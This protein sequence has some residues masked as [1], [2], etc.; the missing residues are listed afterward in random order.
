MVETVAVELHAV[1]EEVRERTFR[2]VAHL[3]PRPADDGALPDHEPAVVGSGSRRRLRG[4]VAQPSAGRARA[5]A[6]GP[7]RAVR[8]VRDAPAGAWRPR[9]PARRGAARVHGGGARARAG[10]A[11][12]RRRAARAGDPPRAPAHRD[13]AAGDDARGHHCR[14]RSPAR[15]RCPAPGWRWSRCAEG[16][17]EQGTGPEGFAYDNERPRHTR[18]D[19]PAS[20]SAARRSPT[21]PGALRPRTAAT[22]GASGGR[23]PAGRGASARASRPR[24]RPARPTRRSSTS[25]SSRPR[26]SPAPTTRGCR[27][28]SSGRRRRRAARGRRGGLGVDRRATSPATR[29]SS[30]TR[31]GSIRKCSSA[32]AT[33]CSAGVPVP[34][35]R[36]SPPSSSVT[37]TSPNAGSS[38]PESGSRDEDGAR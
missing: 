18:V 35:T 1:M 38:L 25:P 30:R 24:R 36:V 10:G 26:P 14:R 11:D 12:H 34:R 37:G 4:S 8:R 31:T 22:R 33:G 28:R 20:R 23:T 29:V 2:L 19:R 6:R 32:T 21:R 7:G 16:P 27:P 13:D 5:L 3:D 17:F 15:R 9:V